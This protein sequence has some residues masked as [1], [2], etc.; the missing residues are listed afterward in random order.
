MISKIINASSLSQSVKIRAVAIF[1]CIA[2]AEAIVHGKALDEIHFH[3]VGAVDAIIDIVGAAIC[4]D[5]L[6]VD[7]IVAS[8]VEL[9][10]GTVRCAHGT[11]PV[12]APATERILA[13]VPTSRGGTGFESTTPTGAAILRTVVSE[14]TSQVSF[15]TTAIGYGIGHKTGQDRPN[16]LRVCMANVT[17]KN[18][19]EISVIIEANIDDMTPEF[20]AY[21]AETMLTA[22]AQDTWITP[23]IMK[24]G[25]PG[26]TLSI[27][28]QESEA[29]KFKN[30][31]F[32]HTSTIGLRTY[33]VSRSILRRDAIELQTA[34]GPITAKLVESPHG[35]R[36]KPEFE[37][38]K[39]LS[40]QSGVPVTEL[41]SHAAVSAAACIK[42][43]KN[44]ETF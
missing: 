17:E 23:V 4:I 5:Y 36:I 39:Q 31:L 27:L 11:M 3:E 42:E 19:S 20:L 43:M 18:C 10:S 25:R 6:K 7:R 8:P 14:F 30:L 28:V 9:G 26:F 21:A 33:T 38:L 1:N 32:I 22:G 15:T 24:K 41:S 16:T 35:L 29:E 40:T 13:G 12:P 34:H 37:S 44:H 2:E